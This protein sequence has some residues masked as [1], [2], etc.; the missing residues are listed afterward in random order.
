[1]IE[2][3]PVT[4]CPA[5]RRD[6]T[7]IILGL[8]AALSLLVPLQV[9]HAQPAGKIPRLGVLSGGSAGNP[10]FEAFRQGLRDLGWVEGKNLI[11]EYRFAEGQVDR[12]PALAAELVQLKVD[13]IAAGPTPPAM[14]AKNATATIPVVMLGAF[15]PVELG[16]VSSLA[17]PGGNVTG[18]SWSV[19]A[20]IAGKGLQ[21]LREALPK[22]ALV[23]VLSNPTNPAH[24]SVVE[25]VK[26]AAQSLGVRLQLLEARALNELESAFRAM[27]KQRVSAVLV[28]ADALF[29]SHREALADLEAKYRLP[30]MHTLRANAEA[31]GLMSYGPDIV[32]VWRRTALVVD[33]ILKGASPADLPVEQPTAYELVINLRTARTLGLRIPPSLQRRADQVLR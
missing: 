32:A 15:A 21:L 9:T 29:V 27:V 8:M 4:P 20:A 16:L 25:N 2:S 33:R 17:R 28:V 24:A 6:R 3:R 31:G 22:L 23:A 11:V 19:D 7:V 10:P 5:D 14:A 18:S 12:L 1:V 13:I 30:S 26:L